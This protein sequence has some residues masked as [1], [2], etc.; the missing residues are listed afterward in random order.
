MG[1]LK[2]SLI[3]ENED[4]IR[5]AAAW[6]LGQIGRH[7]PDHSKALAQADIFSKLINVYKD[8]SS[9]Q[10][11]KNKSQ[12]ALKAVLQ[13]C[14]HLIALQPLLI[15]YDTN[16]LNCKILKYIIQQFAKVLPNDN[17]NRKSFVQCGA[18][19]KIQELKYLYE[20][21]KDKAEDENVENDEDANAENIDYSD[22]LSFIST[23]N[24][25][26]PPE[27]VQYYSPNYSQQLLK[28]LDDFEATS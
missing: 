27:L 1:P 12:R 22:V 8:S 16:D 25:C 3:N 10:D 4:Y 2:D 24:S 5:A 23:I 11:L 6:S 17:N 28:K 7:T 9:S 20:S 19:Q 26:F 14:T 15:N 21:S 13:K 18:L